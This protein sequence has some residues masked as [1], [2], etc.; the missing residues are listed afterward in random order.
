MKIIARSAETAK[1]LGI[2]ENCELKYECL[3]L[4]SIGH[5]RPDIFW[6]PDCPSHEGPYENAP[7]LV[8]PI[9]KALNDCGPNFFEACKGF[10]D[11]VGPICPF[12]P[13]ERAKNY[14]IEKRFEALE[15]KVKEIQV[16][17]EKL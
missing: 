4:G 5:C 16:K 14:F 6:D 11:I 17:T 15:A 9:K 2:L 7:E 12:D 10:V 13:A 1:L 3:N 8:G